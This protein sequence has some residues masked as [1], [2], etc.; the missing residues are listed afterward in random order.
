[1]MHLS[2]MAWHM[3]GEGRYRAFLQDELLEDIGTDR[4]ANTFAALLLPPWCRSFYGDHITLPLA[5]ALLNLLDGV[6]LEDE[7][8]RA[9]TEEGWDKTA[10]DLGN[11]KFDLMIADHITDETL[12][13]QLRDEA[14][15]LLADLGGN[16]G[17]LDDPRRTYN[18]T[19]DDVRLA[20]PELTLRCP[21]EA[22]RDLCEGD[23]RRWDSRS[24]ERTSAPAPARAGL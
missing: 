12:A 6:P 20:Y 19:L 8:R 14:K 11:A 2:A 5:W 15:V 24:R 21:T 1:M 23:S 3:T 9:I 16:G 4:V 17:I 18:V 7:L 10:H 13:T 22:E